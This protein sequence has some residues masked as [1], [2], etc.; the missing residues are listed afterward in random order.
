MHFFLD[1]PDTR[2]FFKAIAF[3]LCFRIHND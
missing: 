3:Q 1:S 2:S